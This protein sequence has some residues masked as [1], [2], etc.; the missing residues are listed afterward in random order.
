MFL[1]TDLNSYKLTSSNLFENWFSFYMNFRLFYS[2]QFHKAKLK[3]DRINSHLKYWIPCD[4]RQSTKLHDHCSSTGCAGVWLTA[5][6]WWWMMDAIPQVYLKI[7]N[8]KSTD[9]RVA[10]YLNDNKLNSPYFA[11]KYACISVLRHHLF[12][13]A[14]S[15]PWALLLENFLCLGTDNVCRQTSVHDF[16]PKRGYCLHINV[17]N[18]YCLFALH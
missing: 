17:S 4:S 12:L 14:H 16:M 3:K 18:M 10:K 9:M 7:F 5:C 11:Q 1:K 2:T 6:P 15:F 8:K 13:K